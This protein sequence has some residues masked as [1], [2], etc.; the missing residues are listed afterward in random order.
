MSK[1]FKLFTLFVVCAISFMIALMTYYND[2]KN[3]TILF[4]FLLVVSLGYMIYIMFHK[5][6]K[7]AVYK[8]KIKKIMKVYHSKLVRIN[9]N[10]E[11]TNENIV[12]AK[13][14]EDIFDLSEE[15]DRPIV[16]L[17]EPESCLFILQ[18]GEDI[19]YYILKQ[20][21]EKETKFDRKRI[22]IEY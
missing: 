6:D 4:I 16:Y 11:L 12:K 3:Y 2:D 22:I 21:E 20:D 19:L 15:F 18:Y 7:K 5:T 17:E 10:Y 13:N 14:L 9:D 1:N 8:K